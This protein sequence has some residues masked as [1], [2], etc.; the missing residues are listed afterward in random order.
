MR[1]V[2]IF[3][4]EDGKQFSNAADCIEYEANGCVNLRPIPSYCDHVPLTEEALRW[5][6]NGDGDCYYATN[7]ARSD[8]L[9]HHS[10]HPE[11]ATHLAYFGK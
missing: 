5:M 7:G 4:A 9:A 10:P 2:T 11:W 8:K 6:L 3:V 1:E